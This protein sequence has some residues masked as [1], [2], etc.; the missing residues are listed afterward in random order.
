MEE[1]IEINS[2]KDKKNGKQRTGRFSNNRILWN[3]FLSLSARIVNGTSMNSISPVTRDYII[4]L[5]AHVVKKNKFISS[6]NS[7]EFS[8][9]EASKYPSKTRGAHSSPLPPLPLSPPYR[10][11][12]QED[13]IGKLLGRYPVE[14]VVRSNIKSDISVCLLKTPAL[15]CL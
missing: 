8:P 13:K 12:E 14:G 10:A 4:N 2:I 1:E 9:A 6:L 3:F 7:L 15:P 11:T 5:R